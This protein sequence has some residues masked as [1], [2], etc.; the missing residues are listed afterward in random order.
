MIVFLSNTK[1]QANYD[2]IYQINQQI[3]LNSR[4]CI[5]CLLDVSKYHNG[6]HIPKLCAYINHGIF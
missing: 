2:D 5:Q 1:K 3:S 6:Y 4:K